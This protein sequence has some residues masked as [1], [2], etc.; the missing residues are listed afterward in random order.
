M[1][2]GDIDVAAAPRQG[3]GA[4]LSPPLTDA[5]VR[6]WSLQ[7]AVG[8]KQESEAREGLRTPGLPPRLERTLHPFLSVSG[9]PP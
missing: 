4:L 8:E 2:S 7:P 3:W 1:S 5:A 9:H 6:T